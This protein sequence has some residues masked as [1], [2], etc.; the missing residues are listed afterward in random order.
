MRF[1]LVMVPPNVLPH[2]PEAIGHAVPECE[3]LAF[4]DPAEARPALREAQAA[5]GTLPP[6]LLACASRL[7]WIA[8]PRAGL[9]PDWFHPALVRSDVVVT[10]TRGI[11]DDHLSH[12]ILGLILAHSRH[13]FYYGQQQQQQLWGPGK[14]IIHLPDCT[15]LI[16][17]CG[18]AGEATARLAKGLGMTVLAT[19]AR[20]THCPQGV[21]ELHPPEA[22]MALLPRADY[23]AMILP[24]TPSTV[25]LMS[26][27]QFNAIKPGAYLINV[28]RGSTL[29]LADLVEALQQGRLSGASLDVFPIEPLPPEHPLWRMPNVL[30]TPH[31]AGEGP[32]CWERRLELLI[33]NCRR[34]AAG[35]T[36][37]NVVDKQNWF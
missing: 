36:L 32:Y 30:I 34:F 18:C 14:P 21:D 1:R 2:W 7:R 26:R 23:V 22:L 8:A 11:F 20:Q 28:G 24:E 25:G 16:L 6:E 37:K 4:D 10:N 27:E 15:L 19:D 35:R 13:F 9:G 29:V 17:G 31:V 33:E 3:V 12:H 5:Y